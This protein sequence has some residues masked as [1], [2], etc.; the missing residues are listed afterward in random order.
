MMAQLVEALHHKTLGRVLENFQVTYS[1]SPH[2]IARGSTQPLTEMNTKEFP[3]GVNYGRRIELT[4]SCAESQNSDGSPTF[5]LFMT[6]Y[7]K[8]FYPFYYYYYYYYK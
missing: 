6:C 4:T 7:G 2:S 3:W 8:Y 1:C 5:H